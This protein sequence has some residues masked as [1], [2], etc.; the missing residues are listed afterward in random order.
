L[1]EL[2]GRRGHRLRTRNDLIAGHNSS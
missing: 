1:R 2:L